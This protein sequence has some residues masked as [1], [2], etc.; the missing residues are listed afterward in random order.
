MFRK[1]LSHPMVQTLVMPKGRS[2]QLLQLLDA[3]QGTQ[4]QAFHHAFGFDKLASDVVLDMRPDLLVGVELRRTRRQ[5]EQLELAALAFVVL[6]HYG[7]LVY[8]VAVDHHEHRIRRAHHQALQEGLEDRGCDGAVV[9]HEAEL[10]LGAHCRKHVEREAPA[11]GRHHVRL[12]RRCPDRV[13][14]IVRTDASLVGKE[15]RRTLFFGL[16]LDGR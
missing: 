1:E 3:A 16:L 4:S 13:R 8:R 5:E 6:A 12:C 7:G 14:V 11:G 9:Q 10:V 15:H 2:D